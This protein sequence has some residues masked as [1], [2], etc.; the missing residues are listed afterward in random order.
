MMVVHIETT[1][2]EQAVK[3]AE[4]L[5]NKKLIYD[6]GFFKAENQT[7]DPDKGIKETLEIILRAKSKSILYASIE[8][9]L[10]QM[11]GENMP[12]M[13]SKPIIQMPH[14]QFAAI[15]TETE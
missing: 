3:I 1:G 4:T 8:N 2:F 12:T 11:F 9:E 13:F 10:K 7:L 14:E 5:L 15:R 6:V